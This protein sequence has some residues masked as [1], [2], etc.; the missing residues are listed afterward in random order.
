MK[1]EKEQFRSLL[2]G[3]PINPTVIIQRNYQCLIPFYQAWNN[4]NRYANSICWIKNCLIFNKLWI[5][6]KYF[7]ADWLV[8]IIKM[9]RK[10]NKRKIS[11]IYKST[12]LQIVGYLKER[13][14]SGYRILSL[15]ENTFYWSI[16]GWM[17]KI[18]EISATQVSCKITWMF[19]FFMLFSTFCHFAVTRLTVRPADRNSYIHQTGLA[20][21]SFACTFLYN[22]NSATFNSQHV[23]FTM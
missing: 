22:S 17:C 13:K 20:L 5:A 6:P 7:T 10:I 4:L 9:L 8:C 21:H 11:V 2:A 18:K 1:M 23:N 3:S 14:F 19:F 16:A 15:T 12:L